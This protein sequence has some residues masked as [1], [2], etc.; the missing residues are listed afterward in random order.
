MKEL[1]KQFYEIC[2]KVEEEI[3]KNS[4]L[5]MRVDGYEI[6]HKTIQNL[7]NNSSITDEKKLEALKSYF[8]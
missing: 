1:F 3:N 5:Q 4:Y 7:L 8:L 6:E 2:D